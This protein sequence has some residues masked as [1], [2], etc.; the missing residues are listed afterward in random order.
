V[1]KKYIFQLKN[2]KE[3]VHET[4]Y[5][6]EVR[7]NQRNLSETKCL[8]PQ[9]SKFTSISPVGDTHR[10]CLQETWINCIIRCF[11]VVTFYQI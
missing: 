2:G 10:V 11:A 3:R 7:G 1:G 8:A 4:T 9:N 6:N 5:E